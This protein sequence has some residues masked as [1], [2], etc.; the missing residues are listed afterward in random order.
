LGLTALGSPVDELHDQL[1]Q[2]P[3]R[4]FRRLLEFR[5]HCLLLFFM[6]LRIAVVKGFTTAITPIRKAD[7]EQRENGALDH[8][9]P[10]GIVTR[11]FVG[12]LSEFS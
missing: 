11:S 10:R 9:H 3:G 2:L 12:R 1:H 8:C 5:H 4:S 6:L 7:G